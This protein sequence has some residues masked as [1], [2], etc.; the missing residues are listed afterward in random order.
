MGNRV[1]VGFPCKL[2]GRKRHDPGRQPIACY[3]SPLDKLTNGL[4]FSLPKLDHD[5]ICAWRA[6]LSTQTARSLTGKINDAHGIREPPGMRAP[7]HFHK[8]PVVPRLFT[9][10]FDKWRRELPSAGDR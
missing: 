1:P 2:P 7:R 3:T 4:I 8:H 9:P 6:D 5:W 10:A